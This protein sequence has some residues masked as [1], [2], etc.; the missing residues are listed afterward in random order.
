MSR[1]PLTSLGT[2]NGGMNSS[3]GVGEYSTVT[4]VSAESLAST[5]GW[6]TTSGR[7]S[8]AE[9]VLELKYLRVDSARPALWWWGRF[10]A[11]EGS[12]AQ[13]PPPHRD[14]DCRR[15]DAP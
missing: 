5:H 13:R 2:G 14:W 3:V 9:P 6:V 11:G 1:N 10:S 8:G 4:A 15:R 12:R 7:G